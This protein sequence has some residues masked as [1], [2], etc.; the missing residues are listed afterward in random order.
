MRSSTTIKADV[1]RWNLLANSRQAKP[2][3]KVSVSI[4]LLAP[5]LVEANKMLHEGG[6]QLEDELNFGSDHLVIMF[7]VRVL[8]LGVVIYQFFEHVCQLRGSTPG[9]NEDANLSHLVL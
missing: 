9:T 8:V 7:N 3:N 4:N 6:G 1:Q 5:W 2:A